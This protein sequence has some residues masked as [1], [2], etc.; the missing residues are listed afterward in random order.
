VVKKDLIDEK[1]QEFQDYPAMICPTCGEGKVHSALTEKD[2]PYY[3]CKNG[4]CNFISW[5]KPYHFLCPLCKNPFLMEFNTHD[6]IIGLKCPK[7]TC[8]Y[9]QDHVASPTISS[10]SQPG[11]WFQGIENTG[12]N[13]KKKRK[14]LVRR[15]L[16]RRKR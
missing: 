7:A 11:L 14:K 8:N 4:D 13:P 12:E 3:A 2:K 1:V 5:G 10:K 16:V 6:G 15:K 9:R